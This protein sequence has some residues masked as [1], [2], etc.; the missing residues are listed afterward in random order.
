M[1]KLRMANVKA[2]E[3][4]VRE[5][6]EKSRYADGEDEE[7]EEEVIV[8]PFEYFNQIN[9]EMGS[10]ENRGII[11]ISGEISKDSLARATRTLLRLHFDKEFHDPVQIIINSPGGY[12]DAGW[13][14][15][16]MISF[17]DLEIRT[18]AMGEC[19]SMAANILISGDHRIVSPN[20]CVMIHQFSWSTAGNYSNLVAQRKAEDMEHD[21]EIRHLIQ[22]SKYDTE[23]EIRNHILLDNDH[24]LTPEEMLSHGLCDEIFIPRKDRYKRKDKAIKKGKATKRKKKG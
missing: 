2:R 10:L 1:A 5:L 20:C 16:D 12:T 23:E 21:R 15:I 17:V 22:H 14:F 13:A 9:R 6:L 7:E 19:C 24:W 4:A 8:N 11:T 3:A 18:I